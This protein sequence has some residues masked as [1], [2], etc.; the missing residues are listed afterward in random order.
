MDYYRVLGVSPGAGSEEIKRAYRKLA[1]LYHPDRNPDP[2][3]ADLFKEITEAYNT[4]GDDESRRLYDLRFSSGFQEVFSEKRHAEPEDPRYRRKRPASY[5]PPKRKATQFDLM[6][7]YVPKFIWIN[8]AALVFV[9]VL[10]LDFFLPMKEKEE[11]IVEGHT[12]YSSTRIYQYDQRVT[13]KGTVMK[14]TP[15]EMSYFEPGAQVII[16]RT[17]IFSTIRYIFNP[18]KAYH[19]ERLGIYGA[20]V[21]IPIVLLVTAVLGLLFKHKTEFAFSLLIASA[22]LFFISL[23][24]ISML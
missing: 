10:V 21:L 2:K 16:E 12:V 22:A 24:L 14:F 8:K 11:T 7:R 19:V 6:K 20:V 5:P 1:V 15:E 13:D 17:L 18:A 4:L 9:A 3:V 23:L